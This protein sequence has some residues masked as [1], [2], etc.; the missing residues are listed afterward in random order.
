MQ[1]LLI[2]VVTLVLLI[3]FGIGGVLLFMAYQKERRATDVAGPDAAGSPQ[4]GPDHA[5]MAR[6]RGCGPD[7]TD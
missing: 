2:V 7:V 6:D 4:P 3:A 1:L 5:W